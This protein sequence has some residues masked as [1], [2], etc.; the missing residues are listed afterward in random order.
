MPELQVSLGPDRF[1]CA[2]EQTLLGPGPGFSDYAWSTG[3]TDSTI[4]VDTTGL[5]GVTVTNRWG[6]Q[7]SDSVFVTVSE[8]VQVTADTS[9]CYGE[10]YY[11][12]GAWQTSSGT[13]VDSLQ[14]VSGCD[15]VIWT[16]LTVNPEIVFDLGR[17]TVICPGEIIALDL[18][19]PGGTY[20]WQDG[21]TDSV[22]IAVEPGI[23]WVEATVDNCSE[24]D[25]LSIGE[26]P[27]KLWFPNAFT[28]NGDGLNDTFRPLGISIGNF[29]MQIFDRWGAM[30]FE[31]QSLDNG[32]D[33]SAGGRECE[34]GVYSYQAA[35]NAVQNQD[36]TVKVKGN[37][38]LVR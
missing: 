4:T 19:I 5:Y 24:T 32:W 9:I 8:S 23:Y 30:I 16:D 37:V 10:R 38:T 14:T 27:S 1:L 28:P 2:G 20:L 31:T 7:A 26:C 13:Y 21:S 22:F 3:E 25:S 29:N 33:G 15:S 18:S 6:C 12:G 36:E 34:P 11:A 17:D 35:W